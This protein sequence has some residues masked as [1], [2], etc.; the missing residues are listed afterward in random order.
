MPIHVPV[1][2]TYL[3]VCGQ[4]NLSRAWCALSG[5]TVKYIQSYCEHGKIIW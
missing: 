4:L 1:V 5:L 3:P 2:A